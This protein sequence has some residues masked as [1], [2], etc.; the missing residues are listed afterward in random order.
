MSALHLLGCGAV[1]PVGLTSF[2]SCAAIRARISRIADEIEVPPPGEPIK[3][4]RV[5]AGRVL[6]RSEQEWLIN[7]ATKALQECVSALPTPDTE[8]ALI[9]CTPEPFRNH[10][11]LAGL[12]ERD[13]LDAF[14][15]FVQLK[16]ASESRVIANG[17]A[18]VFEALAAARNVLRLGRAR[19]CIVGGFDS[20][21]NETDV[22]RLQQMGRLYG[23]DNP[24]GVIPGEGAAFLVLSD[25]AGGAPY[26]SIA[27]IAGFATAP[28]PNPV[29]GANYSVGDGLSRAVQRALADSGSIAE[30]DVDFVVSNHNGERYAAWEST[31]SHARSYRTRRER[32]EVV[33]PASS[34]GDIGAASAALSMIVA[35]VAIARG[36]APGAVGMCEG[37][38]ESELRGAA[39]ITAAARE[40][41]AA[42]GVR[43]RA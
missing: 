16:L 11:G 43:R 13:L 40:P 26:A 41:F 3:A 4:A 34:I 6:R 18:G 28:E 20:L 5:K 37:R 2:A 29:S 24:Q 12:R 10:P 38:S 17:A 36:Y 1:T 9:A 39:V 21:L 23:A 30:P 31:M 25:V 19:Y 32:L 42:P 15:H 8:V 35:A 7:L 27:S 33:Y 14:A 22:A